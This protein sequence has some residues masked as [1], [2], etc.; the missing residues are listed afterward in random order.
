MIVWQMRFSMLVRLTALA[1]GNIYRSRGGESDDAEDRSAACHD[2][3]PS[4]HA[5]PGFARGEHDAD[6]Q[7]SFR[8]P[9]T[10]SDR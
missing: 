6:S 1:C 8:Q 2:T 5:I 10:P 3:A 4:D 7:A 9:Q